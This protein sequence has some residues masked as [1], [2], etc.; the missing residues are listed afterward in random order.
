MLLCILNGLHGASMIV[1][2]TEIERYLSETLGITATLSAWQASK[3][4]PLF[5][6]DAYR[7]VVTE[8]LE[9]PCLLM[10]D[11]SDEAP[12]PATICK[13]MEQ[14]RTKWEGELIY[15]R[16]QV[17]A[18]QRKRLI[19]QRVAFLV[20]G[21]QLYLPMLGIDL[22]EHFLRQRQKRTVLSP[23]AQ[24]LVLRLLLDSYDA[25]RTPVEF[26]KC[27]GYS[28]MTMS[29]AFDELE[30]S[31][32][33][34]I[35]HVGRER[36]LRLPGT[37]KE[38]WENALALLRSPVKQRFHVQGLHE[39]KLGVAAGLTAL[40]NRSMLASPATPEVA[41]TSGMWKSFEGD[42]RL[43]HTTADDP[44][45]IQVQVWRYDPKLFA[46][47]EGV[48]RFSLFLSLRESRDER[49]EAALE[50]MMGAVKW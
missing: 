6:R 39:S 42:K 48:D 36:Q 47:K 21:N 24:V 35:R 43:E 5:L 33:C 13:Q 19:Q 10:I 2:T 40:A 50:E 20:P 1:E 16:P 26:G 28:K 15:V 29:R 14:V 9:I 38:L 3:T 23:A 17:A 44:G 31:Q 41:I 4:V 34:D 18:Y 8:L 22:R 11:R 37:R 46:D 32:L 45:A 12:S 7:F 27:L 25:L 30:T 49:I